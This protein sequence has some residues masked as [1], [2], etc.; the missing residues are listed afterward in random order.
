[1]SANE[2]LTSRIE[3]R[4]RAGSISQDNAVARFIANITEAGLYPVPP[5]SA[6]KR[7]LAGNIDAWIEFAASEVQQPLQRIRRASSKQV[8]ISVDGLI[9][10]STAQLQFLCFCV[11]EILLCK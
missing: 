8:N 10:Q 2:N 3:L 4:T 7:Q 1:M 9:R 6:D 5:F 11:C